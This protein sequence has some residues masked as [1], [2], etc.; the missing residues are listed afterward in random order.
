MKRA[1]ITLLFLALM[2]G[3]IFLH[4]SWGDPP[5]SPPPPPGEHGGSGNGAPAGAP[6][7]GGLGILVALGVA[8]GGLRRYR[9][10]IDGTK[11]E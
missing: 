6:I 7:G 2:P 3:G 9:N 8:Y 5:N 4:K 10:N 11:A 1:L